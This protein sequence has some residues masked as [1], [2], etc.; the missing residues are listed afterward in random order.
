MK[1]KTIVL[2][3]Y[4]KMK[5]KN[6]HKTLTNSACNVGGRGTCAYSIMLAAYSVTMFINF[7]LLE[8]GGFLT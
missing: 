7:L 5:N 4:F 1:L 8:V 6:C 3:K 2:H